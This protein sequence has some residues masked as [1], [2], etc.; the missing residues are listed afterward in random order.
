MASVQGASPSLEAPAYWWYRAR[1][2]IFR[3]V[4]GDW[5]RSDGRLL[6]VGS[7]DGPST[8]WATGLASRTTLDVDPR[9]LAPGG[10]CASALA[11]PFGAGAFATV[12]AFDVVEHCDP[13]ATVLAEFA[14]VLVPGGR[15]LLSV[16]AY[17][18]AWTQFD[19]AQGHHRRYTR[20]RL[21]RSLRNSGFVIE[22]S[23]Y[24]FTATFP[25]FAVERLTRKRRDRAGVASDLLPEVAAPVERALLGL[26]ALD[27]LALRRV[28]LPFGSSVVAVATRLA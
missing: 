28:D 16:P 22:R 7:A 2:E 15:L 1:S 20:R 23:S 8:K 10:V 3:E 27:R 12:C 21:V 24:V 19:V 9:G 6:D 11:L 13:E 25:A 18:W 5:V 26:C 14:R 17:T 4:F